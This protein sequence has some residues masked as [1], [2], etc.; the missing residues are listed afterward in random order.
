MVFSV[1]KLEI[2]KDQE[3]GDTYLEIVDL[4]MIIK[5]IMSGK[6]SL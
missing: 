5:S 2:E 3:N 4:E 1:V 6:K